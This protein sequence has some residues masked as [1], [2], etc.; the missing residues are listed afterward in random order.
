MN[1]NSDVCSVISHHVL[2]SFVFVLYMY[3]LSEFGG[4][5][6]KRV[7][8]FLYLGFYQP[9]TRLTSVYIIIASLCIAVMSI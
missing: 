2:N 8:V 6:V 1:L 9:T 3:V 5:C 7:N 4:S